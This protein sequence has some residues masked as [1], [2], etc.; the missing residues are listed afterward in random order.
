MLKNWIY[1][2]AYPAKFDYKRCENLSKLLL[3]M[4]DVTLNINNYI[5][6]KLICLTKFSNSM[7]FY[8]DFIVIQ[9]YYLLI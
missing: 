5:F 3:I 9:R 1:L 4:N 2:I 7:S 6:R 8:Y